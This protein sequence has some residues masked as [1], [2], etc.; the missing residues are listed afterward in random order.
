[1][2]INMYVNVC[3]SYV[4]HLAYWSQ[5]TFFSVKSKKPR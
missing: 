3:Y 2:Y 1:M 4:S 5:S